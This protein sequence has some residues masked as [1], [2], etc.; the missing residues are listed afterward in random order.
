LSRV[1]ED[2]LREPIATPA[3]VSV[4][5]VCAAPWR[6][7]RPLLD[8]VDENIAAPAM[9]H[10]GPDIPFPLL[11]VFQEIQDAKIVAPR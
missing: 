3:N 5:F 7:C 8:L 1:L 2:L 10:R 6:W 4:K 9:L 11:A